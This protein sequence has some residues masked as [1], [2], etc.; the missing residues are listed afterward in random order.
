MVVAAGRPWLTVGKE[1]S[2]DNQ[3]SGWDNKLMALF[4]N[5]L[6][7]DPDFSTTDFATEVFRSMIV[8]AEEV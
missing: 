7:L 8:V 3:H 4:T 2:L 5:P 6:E 1:F